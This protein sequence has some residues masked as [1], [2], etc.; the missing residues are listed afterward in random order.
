M[1][2]EDNNRVEIHNTRRRNSCPAS[3]SILIDSKT[4]NSTSVGHVT[5]CKTKKF[6]S[7]RVTENS[8]FITES[9]NI[10]QRRPSIKED[11]GISLP[12]QGSKFLSVLNED[13]NVT[14]NDLVTTVIKEGTKNDIDT[15]SANADSGNSANN[16]S[17][18]FLAGLHAEMSAAK[19]PGQ[20]RMI[21][22]ANYPSSNKQAAVDGKEND[23]TT[24]ATDEQ[25]QFRSLSAEPELLSRN[26]GVIFSYMFMLQSFMKKLGD[27]ER[28]RRVTLGS[29]DV[30]LYG[31]LSLDATPEH[32]D[33][34]E[35][36]QPFG[37]TA[38][39]TTAN[40]NA[41]L[42]D[43]KNASVNVS[44]YPSDNHAG[45]AARDIP[46]PAKRVFTTDS[47]VVLH[48]GLPQASFVPS[49]LL[50]YYFLFHRKVHGHHI[51]P[52]LYRAKLNPGQI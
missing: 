37:S 43:A 22:S 38:L 41:V 36:N 15:S 7:R 32:S 5:E 16:N 24:L 10:V 26:D 20:E 45:T 12:A 6:L 21:R 14:N 13:T 28:R 49:F 3:L 51:L 2:V 11:G 52:A 47:H 40:S 46:N 35:E 23:P 30:K 48:T 19:G 39:V 29:S 27:E 44:A 50:F 31:N 42:N 34:E 8:L 1:D 9:F 33:N 18:S 17:N 4:K 25:D